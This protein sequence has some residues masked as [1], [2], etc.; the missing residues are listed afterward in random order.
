[1]GMGIPRAS[2]RIAG[3][4]AALGAAAWMS[5]AIPT[6]S[7]A[8]A[9]DR[10]YSTRTYAKPST[11]ELRRTLTPL[12]YDVTQ[13]GTT[14]PAFRNEYWNHHGA[15][16]YVDVATGEPLFA[17]VHK[18]DSGT[19]WPSFTQPV[20]PG[21]VLT[22]PDRSHGMTRTEVISRGG[23]SHL[24][25]IFDDGPPPAGKRYCINS[26]SLRFVPVAQL[27]AKGYGAYRAAF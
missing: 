13:R 3:L 7:G 1:M 19:G 23:R 11:A 16:L 4:S 15:G 18:F 26:A 17:S 8:L 24:G 21:R 25:H 12:Q 6:G 9:Q 10:V 22:R 14:E 20:E 2:V 5:A 27:E